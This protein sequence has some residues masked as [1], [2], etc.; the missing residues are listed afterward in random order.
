[1]LV[2]SAELIFE[3][4][5]SPKDNFEKVNCLLISTARVCAV[6]REKIVKHVD[7]RRFIVLINIERHK[8][9]MMPLICS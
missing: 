2:C 6:T 5:S 8:D 7:F 3:I 9:M 4:L 1:M